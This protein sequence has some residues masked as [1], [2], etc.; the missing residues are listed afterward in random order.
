MPFAELQQPLGFTVIRDQ[1]V[2]PQVQTHD[3]YDRLRVDHDSVVADIHVK[4]TG[5]R[6]A[7]KFM[8]FIEVP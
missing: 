6:Q 4:V 7:D 8:Y 5:I 3:T 1:K 2:S